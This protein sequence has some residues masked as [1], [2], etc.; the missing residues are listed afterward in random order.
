LQLSFQFFHYLFSSII[1]LLRLQHN[2]HYDPA[3]VLAAPASMRAPWGA[4]ASGGPLALASLDNCHAL[5]ISRTKAKPATLAPCHP[6]HVRVPKQ[7]RTATCEL[8]ISPP[9]FVHTVVSSVHSHVPSLPSI[10]FSL[11]S[12]WLVSMY[13]N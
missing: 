6:L 7:S 10:S 4:H 2:R 11:L 5:G 8:H 1:F 12:S 3:V 13:G 9:Q